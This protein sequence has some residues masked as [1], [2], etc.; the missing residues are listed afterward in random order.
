MVKYNIG[1]ITQ[2]VEGVGLENRKAGNRAGVRIPDPARV[3][4]A[5]G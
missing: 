1:R 5:P 3:R 4:V 2:A